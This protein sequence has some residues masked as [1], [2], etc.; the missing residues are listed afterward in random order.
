MNDEER[1]QFVESK[2]ASEDLI[3]EM[4]SANAHKFYCADIQGKAQEELI[5]LQAKRADIE[6]RM[7]ENAGFEEEEQRRHQ[8]QKQQAT[9]SNQEHLEEDNARA[10]DLEEKAKRI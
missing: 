3:D 10:K 5:Q 7:K 4:L 1:R 6:R 8:E 2:G 9:L